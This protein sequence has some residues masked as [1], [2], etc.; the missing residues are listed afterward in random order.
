MKGVNDID[1]SGLAM[2]ERLVSNLEEKDLNVGFA[3]L[4]RPLQRSFER[5][6]ELR[7]CNI[8]EDVEKGVEAMRAECRKRDRSDVTELMASNRVAGY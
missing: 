8:Y 7:P 1:A 5:S 3:V 2:L 4:K 6:L